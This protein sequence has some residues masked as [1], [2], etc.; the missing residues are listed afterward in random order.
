[1]TEMVPEHEAFA[2]HDACAAVERVNRSEDIKEGASAF[3]EKR[4]P[5]WRG[6]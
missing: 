6:R 3:A 1:M 5:R 2:V 4:A